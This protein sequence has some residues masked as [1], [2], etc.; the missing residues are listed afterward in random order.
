MNRRSSRQSTEALNYNAN[1]VK[2]LLGTAALI[3]TIVI[4]KAQSPPPVQGRVSTTK[5]QSGGFVPGQQRPAGD[6]VQIERGNK[7]YSV[8]CRSCHGADLR[9]GDMGGPESA[10]VSVGAQR[11]RWRI[12]CSGDSRQLTKFG[13][14]RYQHER[15]GCK[16]SGG[17]C[18]K[19]S[20]DNRQAG[21]AAIGWSGSAEYSGWRCQARDRHT[22]KRNAVVVILPSGDLR[23]IATKYPDPKVLQNTWVAGGGRPRTRRCLGGGISGP[24]GDGFGHSTVRENR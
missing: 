15:R 4:A 9:G 24:R 14:A 10:A 1:I 8:S 13:H 23:G 18:A 21:Q 20:R 11:S 12:D 22:F 7:V 19:R 17:I 3:S 16:G 2:V 5:R 6:P